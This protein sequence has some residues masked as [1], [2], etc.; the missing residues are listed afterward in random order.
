MGSPTFYAILKDFVWPILV[1]VISVSLTAYF[2]KKEL[3]AYAIING[4]GKILAMQGF[5][6]FGLYVVPKELS[7]KGEE[8]QPVY[9]IDFDRVPDYFEITTNDPAVRHIEHV[10]PKKYRVRFIASGYGNPVIRCAFR[11]QAYSF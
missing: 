10:S 7:E 1:V 4:D 8:P 5:G 9:D 6:K 2:V 3:P 11:I